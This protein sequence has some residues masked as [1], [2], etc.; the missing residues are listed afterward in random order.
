MKL[1]ERIR[2]CK[3]DDWINAGDCFRDFA[4]EVIQL[5]TTQTRLLA[6][7]RAVAAE[8]IIMAGLL[9]QF[10]TILYTDELAAALA[11][12]EDLL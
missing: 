5:E 11:A 2:D 9:G 8:P 3:P 1:S 4:D 6:V 7:A 10:K 12:V